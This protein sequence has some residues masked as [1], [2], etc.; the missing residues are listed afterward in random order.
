M[1]Q[2]PVTCSDLQAKFL[3]PVLTTLCSAGLQSLSSREGKVCVRMHNSI[4]ELE[5]KTSLGHFGLLCGSEKLSSNGHY[6]VERRQTQ[7]FSLP[8]GRKKKKNTWHAGDPLAVPIHHAIL[9]Q[10]RGNYNNTIPA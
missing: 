10:L 1:A 9:L 4:T 8:N 2:L 7:T 3:H 5:V 6:S